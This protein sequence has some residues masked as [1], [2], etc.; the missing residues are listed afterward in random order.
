LARCPE[1]ESENAGG[2][3]RLQ[4]HPDDPNRGLL[5]AHR[6]FAFG[7]GKN[8]FATAPDFAQIVSKAAGSSGANNNHP[9]G[10]SS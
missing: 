9:G 7:E 3:Q 10:N 5:V 6:N 2:D 8:E 1:D 4:R